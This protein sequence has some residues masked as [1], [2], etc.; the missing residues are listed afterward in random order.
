VPAPTVQ[1]SAPAL[2]VNTLYTV[3]RTCPGTSVIMGGGGSYTVS[4]AAQ[5]NRVAIVQSYPSAPNA[6]TVTVRVNTALGA[7]V[8]LT[9][10]TYAVCTV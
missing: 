6:W 2:P 5:H 9:V 4:N 8:T 10:S 7:G 3:T 1:T